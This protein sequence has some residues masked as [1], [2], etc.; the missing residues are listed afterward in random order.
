MIMVWHLKGSK[1]ENQA[2]LI[3]H[4]LMLYHKWFKITN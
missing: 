3:Q 2:I 1:K 4:K